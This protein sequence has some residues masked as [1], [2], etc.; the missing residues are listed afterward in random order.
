MRFSDLLVAGVSL[1]LSTDALTLEKRDD[2]AVLKLDLQKKDPGVLANSA[3]KRQTVEAPDVNYQNQLLYIVELLIG[4]PPQSTFVQLD[5]G[6]SDL[7]VETP[8]SDICSAAP[9]NPCTNFGACKYSQLH[10][11]RVSL[12][13]NRHRKQFF[14]IPI[15]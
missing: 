4:T 13:F 2:P 14:N 7:V 9:P 11:K 1:A 12:I 15:H 6:S 10:S 5:T 8:L 3:R